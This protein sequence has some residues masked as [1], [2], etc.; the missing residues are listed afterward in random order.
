MLGPIDLK[1]FIERSGIQAELLTLSVQ[2]P[3]VADAARA[4]GTSPERIIKSL[5][6]LVD[7]EPILAIAC[8]TSRIDRRP[9]AAHFSVGRKRVKLADAAKVLDVTGYAIG[10]VP[11]F[12]QRQ[13]LT[14]LIDPGVFEHELVYA[15]GGAIDALLRVSPTELQRV[16]DGIEIDLQAVSS[17]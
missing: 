3:T 17:N 16:T 12:G 15:G 2:T 1:N 6:F 5:V 14:T 7:G 9:I 10:A 8:G 4:V 11:P 13:R